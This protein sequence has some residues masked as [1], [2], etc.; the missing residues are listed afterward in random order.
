MSVKSNKYEVMQTV[1]RMAKQAVAFGPIGLQSN[2]MRKLVVIN[3]V[4]VSLTGMSHRGP[5][6][7]LEKVLKEGYRLSRIRKSC[8]KGFH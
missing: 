7:E 3:G 6:L 5:R 8:L 4:I 2:L 1:Q